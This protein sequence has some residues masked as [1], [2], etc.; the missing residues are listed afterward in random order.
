M[1]GCSV[2]LQADELISDIQRAIEWLDHHFVFNDNTVRSS[3][4]LLQSKERLPY[5]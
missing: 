3:T 1:K 5:P 2:R 4:T